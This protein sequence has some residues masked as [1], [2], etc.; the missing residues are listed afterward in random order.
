[1]TI[2]TG[3][4][5]FLIFMYC[6]RGFALEP[7]EILVIA[8]KNVAES[9][10][11]ARYYCRQ[12]GVPDKNILSL[13]L[14]TSL[15]DTINRSDYEKQLAEPIRS[16]L[17]THKL[18]GQIRCLLT[19]YSVPIKVGKRGPLI[20]QEGKV[21]ELEALAEQEKKRIEQLKQNDLA[22]SAQYKQSN[23]RLAQLQ[24]E[25]DS[26]NGKDTNTSVDSELAM[27]LFGGYDLFR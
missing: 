10:R 16:K 21:R 13:P 17:L 18:F 9:E 25:I 1:M 3:P 19:T 8:N 23:Q 5:I 26:I 6:G 11:I 22:D 2:R 24:L 4:V 14:G 20:D 27:V 15:N 7:D 12:R